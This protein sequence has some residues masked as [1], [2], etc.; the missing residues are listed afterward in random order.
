MGS[1]PS[2]ILGVGA[3]TVV[4]T[5][6]ACNPPKI[7]YPQFHLNSPYFLV[8]VEEVLFIFT[9]FFLSFP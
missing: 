3:L 8:D 9:D 7:L 2:A 4:F 1:N 6:S 5:S